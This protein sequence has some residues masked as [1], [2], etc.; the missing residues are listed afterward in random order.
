MKKE[1]TYPRRRGFLSS[2]S[3]PSKFVLICGIMAFF[4]LI[5]RL[6]LLG[7]SVAS[8][9]GSVFRLQNGDIVCSVEEDE[10]LADPAPLV[11]A[12]YQDLLRRQPALSANLVANAEFAEGNAEMTAPAGYA[13]SIESDTSVYQYLED[14]DKT[15]FLRVLDGRE[16]LPLSDTRPAWL[17][18]HVPVQSGKTYTYSFSYRSGVPVRL[19][20]ESVHAD[21]M[22][23]REVMTLPA[24]SVW[25]PFTAHFSNLDN[26]AAFRPIINTTKPGY[27]DV[28]AFDIHQIADAALSE[29]MVSVT[30]DDGWESISNAAPLLQH[31][32]I[33]TTQYIISEV[34][35]SNLSEYMSFATIN[36]LKKAGHEVGS[37]SLR[38]CNQTKLDPQTLQDNATHSKQLLEEKGLGPVRSFAY[39]LG[40]YNE[41]TQ[42]MYERRFTYIRTSDAGY[43]DRYFDT[44]NIRSMGVLD[45]T[46]DEEFKAWLDYAK[47]HRQWVVLVYHRVNETGPYNVTAQQ[48]ERQLLM[49]KQSQLKVLPLAEAAD[50][51]RQ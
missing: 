30:F 37:H 9:D 13:H 31:Y 44:F 17:M 38:H 25:R 28:K 40:Q 4:Y 20:V 10:H 49:I 3:G 23:Y 12:A 22:K 21:G 19:T 51:A 34:A 15:R 7:F 11:S 2:L 14:M 42:A 32:D 33:R 8:L 6:F 47:T 24:T 26:A 45:K 46:S 29:G 39:P 41:L 43:N 35:N 16:G 48:L 36:K 18:P 5:Y 50:V 1:S 27:V